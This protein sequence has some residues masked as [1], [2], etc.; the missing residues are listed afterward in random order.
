M[1]LVKSTGYQKYQWRIRYPLLMMIKDFIQGTPITFMYLETM[2]CEVRF[3]IT[4]LYYPRISTSIE[5]SR[6]SHP[7]PQVV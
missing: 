5:R 1:T 4:N 2:V 3:K 7:R 6:Y